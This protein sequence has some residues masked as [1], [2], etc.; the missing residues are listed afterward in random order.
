[1]AEDTPL[2]RDWRGL[3]FPLALAIL[4]EAAAIAVNL[5]SDSLA[6]PSE[7]L[8]SLASGLVDGSILQ[9]T[10]Q[11]LLAAFGGLLVGGLAGLVLGV[12][13]G[14][15]RLL[16]RLFFVPIEV[17]R[18][19]PGV[20]IIPIAMLVYGFGYTMEIAVVAFATLWPMLILSRTAVVSIEPRLVEVARLLRLRWHELAM[21]IVLPAITPR[22]FVALRLTVAVALVVA[23]TVEIAANP[24]GLGNA[25]MT[26]QQTLRPERAFALLVWIGVVGWA[27]NW[28]L[29]K[30]EGGIAAAMGADREGAR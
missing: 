2:R 4:A 30:A 22:L 26:A 27:V 20:A 8:V 13:L 24:I 12:L 19:I 1:M 23:V 21:K 3:A 14:F 9:A 11:T 29:V 5:R 15:V 7:I 6:R 16:D 17:M 10:Y 25:M 28:L 18:P